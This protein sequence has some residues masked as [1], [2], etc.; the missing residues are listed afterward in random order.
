MVG[1]KNILLVFI[2]FLS[3]EFGH[4]IPQSHPVEH[5]AAP[6]PD[7]PVSMAV[8]FF[9]VG[10]DIDRNPEKNRE[11]ECNQEKPDPPEVV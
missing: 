11:D 5:A 1:N 7:E 8:M 2:K 4:F 10:K 9:T 6:V 3:G